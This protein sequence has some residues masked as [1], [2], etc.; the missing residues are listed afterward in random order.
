MLNSPASM[1]SSQ[2]TEVT[3]ERRLSVLRALPSFETLSGQALVDIAELLGVERFEEGHEVVHESQ[4]GDRMYLIESGHVGVST[5][6]PAGTIELG[7][8]FAGEMFGEIALLSDAR[9]RRATVMALSPL[10]T[11]TLC[12]ERFQKIVETYPEVR[13]D[14]GCAAEALMNHRL[15]ALMVAQR[16]KLSGIVKSPLTF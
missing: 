13:L 4:L 15:E 11:L 8:L 6:G 3:V 16:E 2:V 10:V 12:L 7:K 9:R 1:I 14:L 5:V